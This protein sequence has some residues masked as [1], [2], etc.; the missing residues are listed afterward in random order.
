MTDL[1]TA[2]LP[3]LHRSLDARF[4]VFDVMH[5]GTHE[6]QISNVFRAHPASRPS[7]SA[8]MTD[9]VWQQRVGYDILQV[10]P[11]CR[12]AFGFPERARVAVARSQRRPDVI[13]VIT[14]RG[15]ERSAAVQAAGGRVTQPGKWNVDSGR[16]YWLLTGPSARTWIARDEDA[17]RGCG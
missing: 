15:S 4:N 9:I 13:D 1:V 10:P 2:L 16:E 7:R 8:G 11:S 17:L 12:K 6:K 5:H 3:V 14:Y